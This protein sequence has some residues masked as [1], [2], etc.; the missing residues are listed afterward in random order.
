MKTNKIVFGMIFLVLALNFVSAVIIN[1]SYVT[2]FPGADGR[3]TIEIENNENFDIEG[4]S[5][6]LE[7]SDLPFITV[8]S[9]EKSFDDIDENDED[10]TSFTL[11]SSTNIIPGDYDIPYVLKYTNAENTSETFE[12]EGNF[13][14]RVS[15]KTDLDFSA[16]TNEN[17]IIGDEGRITIEVVNKGLGEIK[18]V[19]VQII[20]NG[21]ELLSKDKIFVGTITSDDSDTATFDVIYNSQNPSFSAVITYKDFDNKDQTENANFNLKVYT[22]EE[23]LSLGLI[24]QQSYIIYIV[25]GILVVAFIIYRIVKKRKKKKE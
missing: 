19:S 22:K 6:A 10:S 2:I 25:I 23:A 20:P 9:S 24:Q 13:G 21:F 14:I 15:A 8:G 17:A 3:V 16:E 7:L 1:P 4:V 18:S 5:L 12:K 11:K